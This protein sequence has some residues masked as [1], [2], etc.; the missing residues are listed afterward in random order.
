MIVP[1][2]LVN[3]LLNFINDGPPGYAPYCEDR[4]RRTFRNGP[5]NQPPSWIEMQASD[6]LCSHCLSYRRDI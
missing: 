5:R 6:L 2:Q 4:L 3:Y 1:L